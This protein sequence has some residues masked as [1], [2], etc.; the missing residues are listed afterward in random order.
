MFRRFSKGWASESE[1]RPSPRSSRWPVI[2]VSRQSPS[3]L[4]SSPSGA[5]RAARPA[6]A[7]AS[8]L[9]LLAL[10]NPVAHERGARAAVR[11]SSPLIVD[12]SQS[13]DNRRPQAPMTDRRSTAL[14]E[15]LARYPRIEPRIVEA[16]RR[17]RPRHALHPAVRRTRP[18]PLPTCRPRASAAPSLVTDGQVHDTPDP[19]AISSFDAPVHAL[20][21]GE[22]GRVRPPHRDPQRTALRH[23]RRTAG[24]EVPRAPTTA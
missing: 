15:R 11:P 18:R 3:A 23:R 17:C 2:G 10:A 5:R 24:T 4:R 22:E 8:R 9:L 19:T 16:G 13:Q 7:C 14:K 20:I 6:R 21:T 12:R 1:H